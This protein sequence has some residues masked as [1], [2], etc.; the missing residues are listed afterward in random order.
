MDTDA[1]AGLFELCADEVECVLLNACYS[2][3]QAKA[4]SQNIDYVIG[5]NH[6]IG[7]KAAI[8]FA[9]GFYDAL[10]NGKSFEKAYKFG[11]NA[12]QMANIP[13]HLTPQLLRKKCFVVQ[14]TNI[15]SQKIQREQ[16]SA[17]RLKQHEAQK[18]LEE[19]KK[20]LRL[21]EIELL[22]AVKAQYPLDKFVCNKLK[23]LQQSLRLSDEDVARIEKPI[24]DKKEVKYQKKL[25]Q[26]QEAEKIIRLR[27][28]EQANR[29]FKNQE[30]DVTKSKFTIS[31]WRRVLKIF[32]MFMLPIPC[33][34]MFSISS[35]HPVWHWI[36]FV[37]LL[38]VLL[39]SLSDL[40]K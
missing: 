10:F 18:Q 19:K 8:E 26:Q 38:L 27:E 1:L 24:L 6:E 7:D 15:S 35:E 39:S 29:R 32:T 30:V 2:E 12:I 23:S 34:M 13:E 25:Q 4:I 11:R 14:P 3:V 22:R 5:M 9:V 36:W 37:V 40:F 31:P 33:G 21:Y 20:N 28:Q 17:D 16:E